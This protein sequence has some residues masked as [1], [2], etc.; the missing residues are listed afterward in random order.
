MVNNSQLNEFI[1]LVGVQ[2]T[3]KINEKIK[4]AE[5]LNLEGITLKDLDILTDIKKILSTKSRRKIFLVLMLKS[6]TWNRELRNNFGITNYDIT[7][8]LEEFDNMGLILYKDYYSIDEIYQEVIFKTSVEFSY[9]IRNSPQIYILSKKGQI[10]SEKIQKYFK[11]LIQDDEQLSNTFNYIIDKTKH[12]RAILNKI[13]QEEQTLLY[14]E[15]K[16]P[17]EDVKILK[18]TE[19]LKE[20]RQISKE[21][22]DDYLK[23]IGED[24]I[25]LPSKPR[26]I[27]SSGVIINGKEATREDIKRINIKEEDNLNQIGLSDEEVNSLVD[28]R[29]NI[30]L[31]ELGLN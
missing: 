21:V 27:S 19:K 5:N 8:I 15:I 14:R 18:E 22:R 16:S 24:R 25:Y 17:Y 13:S 23:S 20:I 1:S 9:W 29:Q 2:T 31:E 28:K 6:F 12:V 4:E 30:I 7:N 10:I 3:T 11:D 26:L